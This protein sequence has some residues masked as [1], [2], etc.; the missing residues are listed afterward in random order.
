[1][2]RLSVLMAG[3]ILLAGAGAASALPLSSSLTRP[4]VV[5]GPYQGEN[6]LQT[7]LDALFGEGKVSASEDQLKQG[8][9]RVS[10]P[11]SKLIA[12]QFRFEWTANAG[13]QTVGIFGWN[14]NDPVAAQIFSGSNNAGDW[15]NVVWNSTNSGS[16]ITFNS[17]TNTFGASTFSGISKNFFGFYFD[18]SGNGPTY[19]TVDSLNGGEARVLSFNG[20]GTNSGIA[21][22]YEDG[23]D[24][25]FQDAGFFVESIAPVPE[26]ATVL[27]LG[28]GLLGAA[29]YRRKRQQM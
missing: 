7:E 18:V 1:M 3:A 25:D 16:I 26:P 4:V 20:T 6:S 19:Y 11:G 27:L 9:F 23:N 12:P 24:F 22:S 28:A 2:R 29:L 14:G 8:M 13:N 15:A 5:N 10:T 17:T 21:F